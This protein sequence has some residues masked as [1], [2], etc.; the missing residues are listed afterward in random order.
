[1]T[2]CMYEKGL[3]VSLPGFF[4]CTAKEMPAKMITLIEQIKR[5]EQIQAKHRRQAK[6]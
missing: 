3:Y 6:K 1:M 4:P 2:V 5:A